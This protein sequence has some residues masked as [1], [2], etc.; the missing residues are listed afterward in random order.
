MHYFASS[1]FAF[2]I[3]VGLL[4][5]FVETFPEIFRFCCVPRQVSVML[6]RVLQTSP[7]AFRVVIKTDLSWS[8]VICRQG[9]TCERF[10]G[11]QPL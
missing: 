3:S 2:V 7:D 6:D 4:S 5:H 10:L 9:I 8:A 11:A 1:E